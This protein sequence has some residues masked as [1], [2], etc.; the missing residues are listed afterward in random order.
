[1]TSSSTIEALVACVGAEAIRRAAVCLAYHIGHYELAAEVLN[2]PDSK[3]ARSTI[4]YASRLPGEP[5][6]A[7]DGIHLKTIEP[8]ELRVTGT[9]RF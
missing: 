9:A 4:I 1:M 2:M 5:A 3:D 6:G 7:I 8:R